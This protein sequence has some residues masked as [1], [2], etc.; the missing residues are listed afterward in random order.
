MLKRKLGSVVGDY[1]SISFL[2][3]VVHKLP[4]PFGVYVFVSH[5]L[6]IPGQTSYDFLFP[7]IPT[8][9]WFVK[10]ESDDTFLLSNSSYLNG[11][12]QGPTPEDARKDGHIR[13]RS[14]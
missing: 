12:S 6:C 9:L 11:T 7:A 5:F 10:F 13:G 8:A 3:D 1:Q 4:L 14:K 2:T